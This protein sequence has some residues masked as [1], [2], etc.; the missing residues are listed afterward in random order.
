MTE[1]T[2]HAHRLLIWKCNYM[3]MLLSS[4]K[5]KKAEKTGSSLKAK[6]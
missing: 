2:E 3:F 1:A 5:W 4:A 6:C